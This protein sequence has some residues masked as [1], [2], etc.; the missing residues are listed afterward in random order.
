MLV[1]AASVACVLLRYSKRDLTVSSCANTN[2]ATTTTITELP[3]L[4]HPVG[5][6]A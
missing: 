5:K 4:K 1:A 2:S 6:L 3:L